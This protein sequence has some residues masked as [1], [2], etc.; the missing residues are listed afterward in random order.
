[1]S[2]EDIYLLVCL[3]AVNRLIENGSYSYV[4]KISGKSEVVLLSEVKEWI[5]KQYAIEKGDA[6]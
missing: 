6:E 3:Y 5:E 4:V 1:M 2:R